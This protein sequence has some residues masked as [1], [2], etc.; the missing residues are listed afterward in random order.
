MLRLAVTRAIRREY[1][2]I[3]AGLVTILVTRFFN[4]IV[5]TAA[6]INCGFRNH[7]YLPRHPPLSTSP[8]DSF[9]LIYDIGRSLSCWIGRN[10]C[11]P[12][13]TARA[14]VTVRYF[15]SCLLYLS[16]STRW[17]VKTIYLSIQFTSLLPLRQI[18]ELRH[19]VRNLDIVMA[20]L[21][22][23]TF[24]ETFRWIVADCGGWG[25]GKNCWI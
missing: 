17:L 10:Q 2:V 24:L 5:T 8:T 19:K 13:N 1:T 12:I 25:R 20:R 22:E 4:A 21:D 7:E 3:Q 14:P 15:F 9:L 11:I 16:W 6:I 18:C 23:R